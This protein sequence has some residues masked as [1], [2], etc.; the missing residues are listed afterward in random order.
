MEG[1]YVGCGSVGW[2]DGGD[3]IVAAENLEAL[4]WESLQILVKY[5]TFQAAREARRGRFWVIFC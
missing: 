3:V 1:G 4:G 2:G 5:N